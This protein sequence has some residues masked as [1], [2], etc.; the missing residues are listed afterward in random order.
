M[1][2]EEHKKLQFPYLSMN[3]LAMVIVLLIWMVILPEKQVSR[4]W[5]SRSQGHGLD[6]VPCI[7]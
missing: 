5:A 1:M 7:L 4:P 3:S 2:V 6:V